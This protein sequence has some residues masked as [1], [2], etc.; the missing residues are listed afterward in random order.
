MNSIQEKAREIPV[1]ETVDILV[2]GGGPAGF[3]AA[4]TAGKLG[5]KVMLIEQ[6]GA[7]GG[8]AT[9]GIMSHWTGHQEGGLYEEVLERTSE[10]ECPQVIN[11]ESLK[12]H[13]LEMLKEANVI[14]QLYTFAC[15]PILEGDTIK[16]V[17]VESKSGREAILAKIVIDSSGDGDIAARS[18]V[19]FRKGREGDGKMQPMTIMFKVANVDMEQAHFFWGFEDTIELP[20]GD[21][22]T[23]GR[24]HLPFPAGHILL[25]P[26]TLPGVVTVNMTNAID[27]DGTDVR[28]LVKAEYTCRRQIAPIVEFLRKFVPGYDG[29]FAIDSANAIGVRETRRFEASHD[30]SESDI[31]EAAQFDDWVVTKVKFF[32]DLHN[33]SGAGLDS[34]GAY[35]S[36]TQTKSYTIPFR[37]FVPK[38][39]NNLLLNGRNIAGTHIAHSSYRVMPTCIN[40]GQAMGVA[41]SLCVRQ[42]KT[43]SQLDVRDIQNEL[44]QLGVCL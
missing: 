23:L 36:F 6:S 12:M 18:G 15:E 21:L 34:K 20:D 14:I 31:L 11:P 27:V 26:A 44:I 25:Y 24:K 2:V 35:K 40:M 7:I 29:C 30:L 42:Q 16:G 38:K 9:T 13:L 10:S 4:Y 43:P 28:D 19:P 33:V 17:I 22:Q 5:L 32:F 37:C 1:Y 41:A 39:I 3:G 8:V